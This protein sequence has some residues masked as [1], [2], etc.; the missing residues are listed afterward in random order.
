MENN[1]IVVKLLSGWEEVHKMGQLTLWTMLS[2]KESPKPMVDIKKFMITMTNGTIDPE[3]Q[4]LY[5][6]LRKYCKAGLI[7]YK[8]VSSKSGPKKKSYFLTKTGIEVVNLFIERNI[9]DIYFK[10]TVV[11]LLSRK[12]N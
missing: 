8:E 12:E 7:D 9:T 6:S 3:D 1:E 5:R 2:L 4:S 11:S 10:D